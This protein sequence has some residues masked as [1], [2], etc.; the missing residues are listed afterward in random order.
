MRLMKLITLIVLSLIVLLMLSDA[1]Q[2]GGRDRFVSRN[3]I[4][5]RGFGFRNSVSA[6]VFVGRS[7]NYGGSS[8]S[9]SFQRG[10]SYAAPQQFFVERQQ[11][12]YV[13]PPQQVIVR[14][15]R[16]IYVPPP[17]Q[18]IVE[19]QQFLQA[20]QQSFSYGVQRGAIQRST[21]G[22]GQSFQRDFSQFNQCA[23]A[24]QS[25][26]EMQYRRYGP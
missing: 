4:R 22:C 13:P 21:G 20:P 1:S 19:R 9:F 24:A 23:P 8:A 7:T 6:D 14:Q 25:F 2:A 12:F 15:Q 16:D 26:E 18:I 11:N 17:Q 10:T 5:E 3:V